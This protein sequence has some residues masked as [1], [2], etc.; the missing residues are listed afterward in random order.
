MNNSID[1]I[2]LSFIL[3]AIGGIVIL[4]IVEYFCERNKK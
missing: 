1:P 4:G 3:F 2:M